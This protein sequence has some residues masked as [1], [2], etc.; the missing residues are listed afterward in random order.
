MSSSLQ[1]KV[2]TERT[3]TLSLRRLTL[4]L[5]F[6]LLAFGAINLLAATDKR[7]EAA[8]VKKFDTVVRPFLDNYCLS[9]HDNETQKGD[10]DLSPY[11]TMSAVTR[12]YLHWELV[13]DRLQA[14][15]MPPEK[16]KKKPDAALRNDVIDWIHAARKFEADR[17]AGDPGS[18][19]ARRLSN[20][21]YNN[22]IRDLTGVDLKPTREFP[23]DPANQAGFD[24]TGE[25]L[26]MP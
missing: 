21:E 20:S 24:N 13:L 18:V 6:W 8:L 19:V 5:M 9:C 1:L 3:G 7:T 17:N 26:T 2:S 25:S 11:K 16:A 4:T 10:F 23:V 14:R 15:E 12:D 22:S